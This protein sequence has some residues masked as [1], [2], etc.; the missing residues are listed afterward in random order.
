MGVYGSW[1]GFLMGFLG[2]PL[3][4][5]GLNRGFEWFTGFIGVYRGL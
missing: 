3:V 2:V 4:N 1:V 5:G